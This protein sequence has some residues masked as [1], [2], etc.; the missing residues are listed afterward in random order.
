MKFYI[1]VIYFILLVVVSTVLCIGS[2]FGK[3]RLYMSDREMWSVNSAMADFIDNL[4][5]E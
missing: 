5:E 1:N 3:I 2:C 4:L